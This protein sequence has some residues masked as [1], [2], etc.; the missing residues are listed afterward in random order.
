MGYEWDFGVV[1]RDFDLL[2]WGLLNTLKVTVAALAFGVPL[3][4][5]VAIARLSQHRLIAWPVGFFI[6]FFRSTPPLVQLFWFFFAMP[7]LLGIRIDPFEAAV[8]TLSLQSSA[9]FAATR[10]RRS[11]SSRARRSSVRSTSTGST[12]ARRS[13]SVSTWAD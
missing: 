11:R 4:L 12:V 10:M 1:L 8:L 6:E 9:F 5:A 3:G 13:C 2:L 7:I